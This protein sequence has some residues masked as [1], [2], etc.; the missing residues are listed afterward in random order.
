MKTERDPFLRL[1]EGVSNA[2]G[3][4]EE[5]SRLPGKEWMWTT[6]HVRFAQVSIRDALDA[7]DW[8][9]DGAL[10]M[11][12]PLPGH[13]FVEPGSAEVR[14]SATQAWRVPIRCYRGAPADCY[15]FDEADGPDPEEADEE[16]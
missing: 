3:Y 14:T 6:E 10:A 4:L 8:V 11:K 13:Q 2:R 7:L 12:Q 1:L 15:Q 9:V 5:A 16:S